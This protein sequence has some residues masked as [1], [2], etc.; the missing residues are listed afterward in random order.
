MTN[1]GSYNQ[2]QL[3]TPKIFDYFLHGKQ[4]FLHRFYCLRAN[5]LNE[6][7]SLH[8]DFLQVPPIFL[9]NQFRT[10][11]G[12]N[13]LRVQTSLLIAYLN[14]LY[15]LQQILLFLRVAQYQAH[16]NLFFHYLRPV[17]CHLWPRLLLFHLHRT[18]FQKLQNQDIFQLLSFQRFVQAIYTYSQG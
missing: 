6:R 16:R 9:S 14:G 11:V 5:R 3:H 4:N 2:V 18:K 12:L 15:T 1:T 17:P 7:L 10:V 13:F 8:H